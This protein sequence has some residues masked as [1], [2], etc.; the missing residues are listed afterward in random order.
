MPAVC[1]LKWYS[2]FKHIYRTDWALN[3][4]AEEWLLLP[5]V[6]VVVT[7]LYPCRQNPGR[8]NSAGTTIF[9]GLHHCRNTEDFD[10]VL[11]VWLHCGLCTRTLFRTHRCEFRCD[12]FGWFCLFLLQGFV[13]GNRT[14]PFLTPVCCTE[15][16]FPYSKPTQFCKDKY[17][18]IK[19][20][21]IQVCTR[22][23][24]GNAMTSLLFH[25]SES[26]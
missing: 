22:R 20:K 14:G 8:C 15:V 23:V 10:A 3:M 21:P 18:K 11:H 7:Q 12:V 25:I 4:T 26:I 2:I 6:E 13:W 19:V 17:F 1:F 24:W 5:W 9:A 16:A